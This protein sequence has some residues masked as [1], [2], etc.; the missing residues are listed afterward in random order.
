MYKSKIV[1]GEF[2]QELTKIVPPEASD[3]LSAQIIYFII[4]AK[5]Y[6]A[7]ALEEKPI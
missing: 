6:K 3:F 2:V 5:H 4:W 7:A 1:I